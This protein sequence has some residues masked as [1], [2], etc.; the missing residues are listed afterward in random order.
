MTT[1]CPIGGHRRLASGRPLR[2]RS[3]PPALKPLTSAASDGPYMS[4]RPHRSLSVIPTKQTQHH[5]RCPHAHCESAAKAPRKGLLSVNS[6]PPS[7]SVHDRST[8]GVFRTT[9]VARRPHRSANFI[10]HLTSRL[11]AAIRLCPT[12]H[13]SFVGS[14]PRTKRVANFA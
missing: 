10:G 1:M 2:R 14:L 12:A 13:T 5:R 3:G 7:C 9:C 4:H 8:H 6:W 11:E